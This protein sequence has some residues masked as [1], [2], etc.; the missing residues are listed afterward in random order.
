MKYVPF[1]LKHLRR[2]WVRTTSTVMAMA[3]CI[4]L[5][6]TLQTFLKAVTWNL[7]SAKNGRLVVQDHISLI[8]NVPLSYEARIAAIPGVK[9]VSILTWFGGS[10]DINKP[11]DFFPNMGV[12]PETYLAMYPEYILP[13]DQKRAFINDM[14][15]CIVGR[16]TAERFH[17]KIGDR[18]QLE[19]FIPPYRVGKPFE[20]VIDGIFDADPVQHP[21]VDLTQMFFNYKYL[22]EA[23]GRRV[24][25]GT[26]VVEI[27][28]PQQSGAISKTVDDLFENSDNQ[29]RTQTESAFMAGFAS[30]IGNLA[31]LLNGIAL[32]VMF[33]IL[34]VTANTMS[35]A[36]RERRT[37]I[38]V[39]KTLGF[40]SGLVMG[41]ILGES[42]VLGALG[43]TVG[44]L[45]GRATIKAL[46]KLP[47]IG[48]AVRG[49]PNLGMSL[50]IGSLGMG[51]ALFLGL[52]AG[53]VPAFLAYRAR[54]TELLRQI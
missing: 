21:G 31:V 12:E 1:I 20:F 3:V 10:R 53:F 11:S 44:I 37:E 22:Y 40:P 23:S 8:Y 47:F 27:N 30:M 54:V 19:S 7:Q 16:A 29:T 2:N 24:G 46:P 52:A 41:L 5:F 34:L 4:F 43:G 18:F 6:C 36:V 49:F 39:L 32:A 28:D 38:A 9:R 26:Y 17:W 15:G 14:R 35:M 42:L 45:L 48:D 13:E 33:T 25:A 50:S 51:V